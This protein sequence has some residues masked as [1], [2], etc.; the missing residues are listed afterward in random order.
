MLR[1]KRSSIV[2]ELHVPPSGPPGVAPPSNVTSP[3][4]YVSPVENVVVA[5][6][7]SKPPAPI[8]TEPV[9]SEARRRSVVNVDDAV[10]RSPAV[11]R[12]DVVA[13]PPYVGC[14][15]ASY[16]VKYVPKSLT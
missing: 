13:E 14:V 4:R 9:P 1:R 3:F 8:P 7:Y 15:H 2:G 12:S 11:V 10:E 5:A 6:E 16:E